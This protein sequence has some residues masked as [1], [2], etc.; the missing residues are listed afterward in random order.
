MPSIVFYRLL[1]IIIDGITDR[2][3]DF[4]GKDKRHLIGKSPYKLPFGDLPANHFFVV[5]AI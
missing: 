1:Q 2:Y 3:L 5:P 4:K